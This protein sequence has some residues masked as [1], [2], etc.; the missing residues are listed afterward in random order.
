MVNSSTSNPQPSLPG[1]SLRGLSPA[2]REVII[3]LHL[4]QQLL[5]R[6]TRSSSGTRIGLGVFHFTC[7]RKYVLI[8]TLHKLMNLGWVRIVSDGPWDH[9]ELIR[10]P[11]A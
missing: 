3:R 9:I 11:T 4:G 7:D 10:K 1:L 6:V 8:A 2:Q 5:A